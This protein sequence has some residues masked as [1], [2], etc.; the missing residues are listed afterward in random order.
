MIVRTW[1]GEAPTDEAAEAYAEHVKN[2]AFPK[3]GLLPGHIG[4][5][6]FKKR[7]AG[8]IVVLV[9]SY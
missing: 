7:A 3:M 5:C 9:M 4:A 1:R 6:L 2:T 8:K